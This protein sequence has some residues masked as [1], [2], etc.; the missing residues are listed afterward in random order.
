MTI[1]TDV[2]QFTLNTSTGTQDITG[3]LDSLTPKAV[4]FFLSR[5]TSN[6]SAAADATV[7]IGAATGA[8]NEWSFLGD[9][10]DN[11]ASEDTRCITSS[12][13][14]LM[15]NNSGTATIL[16]DAEF[17]A[18]ITN[19]VR[20]NITT[21]DAVAYKG[22]AIFFAGD[23]LTA[24]ADNAALGDTTDLETNITAPGFEPEL[25]F[26]AACNDTG[27]DAD[28][29]K[30]R[31][32]F[33]AAHYD[34]M[35]ITQRCIA[36]FADNGASEGTPETELRN[37]SGIAGPSSIA[38]QGE[39]ANFDSSGFSV[40]TRNGGGNDTAMG[41]LAL[42]FGGTVNISIDTETSP[43]STGNNSTTNAGFE[44]QLVLGAQ[45]YVQSLNTQDDTAD[46]GAWG[47]FAFNDTT[48]L[49]VSWADEDA[50]AT[51]NTQ[52][53]TN[54]NAIDVPNDDG[55]VALTASFVS[56]D[57]SGHTLNWSDVEAAGRYAFYV[58]IEVGVQDV[59]LYP[60][61][62]DLTWVLEATTFQSRINLY[63][64]TLSAGELIK[65]AQ[66]ALDATT[67]SSGDVSPFDVSHNL[68]G[69]STSTGLLTKLISLVAFTG[70][71][72][73]A[74]TLVKTVLKALSGVT[75]SIGVLVKKVLKILSGTSTSTGVLTPESRTVIDEPPKFER[76]SYVEKVIYTEPFSVRVVGGTD[77][78]LETFLA[79][80][81]V[82]T[83]ADDLRTDFFSSD[84]DIVLGPDQSITKKSGGGGG[85]GGGSGS[86]CCPDIYPMDEEGGLVPIGG[87]IFWPPEEGTIPLGWIVY[88][89][90]AG[91][92]LFGAG[93][94]FSAGATGGA[95]TYD[96]S[97]THDSGT[98]GTDSDN[99]THGAGSY[100]TDSDGHNHSLSGTT[101][102][103][104]IGHT[105]SGVTGGPSGLND[106]A[107]GTDFQVGS[108]GHTHS[109]GSLQ[110]DLG[111]HNHTLSSGTVS[112]D[113]HSHDVSGTSGSDS[114][115]HSV[116][117]GA[118]GTSGS[119][120]Q[121][122][123]PPYLVGTWIQFVGS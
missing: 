22:T 20:I 11:S 93:G 40:I 10:E 92:V 51:T 42:D 99:H 102:T 47:L 115:S 33:G 58:S 25:V 24:Y 87:V 121:S 119:A 4:L 52:S 38:W 43:T 66:K 72:T 120:V 18:F 50:A 63:A 78:K 21:S 118:S 3:S 16:M 62:L 107:A 12:G 116:N 30:M 104:G 83:K 94:S 60:D 26:A 112:S 81:G 57:A 73:S 46:G 56:M 76:L 17:S 84:R 68:S 35:T 8:S 111:S 6:G 105:I 80:Q 82:V 113:S 37:D 85:G 123:L 9:S 96:L 97:H 110:A 74:G 103:T 36:S 91:R 54:T 39:F 41:Y 19:G 31:I 49:C 29:A 101:G 70:S 79:Q 2:V 34:G 59:V 15:I 32:S 69:T 108:D 23:D 44:P 95:E 88:S 71:S 48:E 109:A 77:R 27:I 98:Y 117:S 13:V 90:A 122:T 106:V 5:A 89:A 75:T 28:S 14:C 100:S 114:H 1:V 7:C 53:Y 64:T 86:N 67:T 65:Q 45:A 61:A 55:T